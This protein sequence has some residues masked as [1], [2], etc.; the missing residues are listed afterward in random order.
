MV[1]KTNGAIRKLHGWT[2]G[3]QKHF[4]YSRSPGGNAN[5]GGFTH[6]RSDATLSKMAEHMKTRT[7]GVK[8]E[9]GTQY[10]S[11]EVA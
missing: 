10:P 7:Q 6:T 4:L 8:A 2:E 1:W 9:I 5:A 11:Q 3:S